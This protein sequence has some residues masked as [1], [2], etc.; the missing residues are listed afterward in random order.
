M[1]HWVFKATPSDYDYTKELCV[2]REENWDSVK[3]SDS[4]RVG[5]GVFFWASFPL[6]HVAGLGIVTK[7]HREGGVRVRYLTNCFDSPLPIKE[8]KA[9]PVLRNTRFFKSGSY[10]TAFLLTEAERRALDELVTARNPSADIGREHGAASKIKEGIC[11]DLFKVSASFSDGEITLKEAREQLVALGI[12]P[13]SATNYLY[14]SRHILAGRCYKR[15]MTIDVTGAFLSWIKVHRIPEEYANSLRA[16]E[17]HIQYFEAYSG[18]RRTKLRQLLEQHKGVPNQGDVNWLGH[19]KGSGAARL[20]QLLSRGATMDELKQARGGVHSHIGHLRKDWGIRCEEKDG[21]WRMVGTDQPA[22]DDLPD[23]PPAGC[24]EPEQISRTVL[25]Y[26][27]DPAVRAYVL[28]KAKGRCEYCGEMGFLKPD[29]KPYLEAHHLLAL[30]ED[31][32]DTSDNVVALCANHHREAH[33]G[34]ERAKLEA[35]VI[36][37]R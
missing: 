8:L 23:G 20:D 13:G 37:K 29:G 28:S 21:K 10:G 33:Y 32:P 22:R 19:R 9:L 5:D 11:P 36:A 4:M 25:T 14:N 15:A 24:E 12:N 16:L 30:S 2:G 18:T 31:G 35:A 34:H 3:A 26:T 6:C 17:A 7:I 27:R 1:N